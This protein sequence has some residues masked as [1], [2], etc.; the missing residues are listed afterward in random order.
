[1]GGDYLLSQ[2]DFVFRPVT[3]L[4]PC[5]DLIVFND[6]IFEGSEDLTLTLQGFVVDG[7]IT[8]SL[9]G[10]TIDPSRA[11]ITITDNDSEPELL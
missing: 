8:P 1:M 5:I 9:T 10:I 6:V 7:S 4:R 2:G 3:S 11:T